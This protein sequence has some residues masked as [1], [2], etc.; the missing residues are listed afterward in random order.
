MAI[1]LAAVFWPPVA[2][3]D[4]AFSRDGLARAGRRSPARAVDR[5]RPQPAPGARPTDAPAVARGGL[6]VVAGA[7]RDEPVRGARDRPAAARRDGPAAPSARPGRGHRGRPD[8]RQR[9]GLRRWRRS[10]TTSPCATSPRSSSRFGPTG[11]EVE[12]PHCEAAL[13]AGTTAD[14]DLHLSADVDGRPI[15]AVGLTGERAG[16]DVRWTADVASS[17][18]LGRFGVARIGTRAWTRD[19]QAGWVAAARLGSR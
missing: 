10:P 16:V 2:R 3:G 4:R 5:R 17:V 7:R 8:G 19:P 14:L 12:P 9:G 11:G 6:S 1:A 13:A 18:T 15:G